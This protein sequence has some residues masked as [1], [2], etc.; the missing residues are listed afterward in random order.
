[1]ADRGWYDDTE[2][3]D[4]VRR[5]GRAERFGWWAVAGV[6]GV[7]GCALVVL[8]ASARSRSWRPCTS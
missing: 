8:A 1:M 4:A 7:I 6:T 5:A 3:E 2:Y